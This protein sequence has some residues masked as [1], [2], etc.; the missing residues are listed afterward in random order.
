MSEKYIARPEQ[1]KNNNENDPSNDH[2]ERIHSEKAELAGQARKLKAEENIAKIKELA[3]AEAQESH[4]IKMEDTGEKESDDLLGMQHSL[5]STA[6]ER[7]L[8]R[9]QHKLPKSAR[10]FSKAIHAPLVD[11][12][13]EISTK[14]VARPSGLLG[15]SICAFLGSVIVLYY[16]KHYGFKYNYLLLFLLFVSG[17][18]LGATLEL[19][20]WLV[21]YRR[22]RQY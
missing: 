12:V 8:G 11:K 16:S 2:H 13:S 9:I 6:Y 22:K 1:H 15:G 4:K 18:V 19:V 21:Y 14:T 10:A 5:K 7:T 20:L 17:F 3:K